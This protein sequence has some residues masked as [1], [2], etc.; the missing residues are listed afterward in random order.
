MKTPRARQAVAATSIVL[1]GTLLTGCSSDSTDPQADPQTSSSAD[2]QGSPFDAELVGDSAAEVGG[3]MT[4]TLT[5]KGRLPDVY[6]VTVDP[7][8]AAAVPQGEFTLSPGESARVRIKVKSTPFDVHLKSVGG[9]A[10]DVVAFT[11]S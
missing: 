8:D 10:P 6:L 3:T 4:A 9:G 5:N 1:L 11:V 2:S 7:A